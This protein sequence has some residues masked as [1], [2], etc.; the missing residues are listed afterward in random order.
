MT[1]SSTPHMGTSKLQLYAEQILMRKTGI[2]Q[3]RLS[4]EMQKDPQ[5]DRW[6]E[7]SCNV[8]RKHHPGEWP[9]HRRIN[10]QGSPQ[11]VR[12][13]FL[14]SFYEC[15]VWFWFVV[16]IFSNRITPFS[17]YLLSLVWQSNI[18]FFFFLLLFSSATLVVYG[19]SQDRSWIRATAAYIHHIHS[20]SGSEPQLWPTSQLM[21]MP[22]P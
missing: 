11:G 5:W 9:P 6:E 8:D 2:C 14:F 7:W 15:S 13:H 3:K 1:L 17:I 16:A 19:S 4:E 20:T 10:D 21:T 22:D 12:D 18:F